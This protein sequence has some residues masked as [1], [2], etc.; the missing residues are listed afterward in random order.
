[1]GTLLKSKDKPS[2][3]KKGKVLAKSV[4]SD[5]AN[6]NSFRNFQVITKE[7]LEKERISVYG[8]LI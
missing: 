8:Y 1:M 7:E 3:S 5:V 2:T 4:K 6:K